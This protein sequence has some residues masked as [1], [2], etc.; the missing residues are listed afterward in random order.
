MAFGVFLLVVPLALAVMLWPMI[1]ALRRERAIRRAHSLHEASI[2]REANALRVAEAHAALCAAASDLRMADYLAS[3]EIPGW[4]AEHRMAIA[5]TSLSYLAPLLPPGQQDEFRRWC[6]SFSDLS[7]TIA[8]HN[9]RVVSRQVEEEAHFF[10][11]IVGNPL[12]QRQREAIVTNEDT[13]LVVAGAGTGK[14]RV[15]AAKVAWLLH[16][17]LAR[18]EEILVLAYNRKA[19]EEIKGRL[20]SIP[21]ASEVM[22]ST[23]H[24]FGLSILANAS[25]EKPSVSALADDRLAKRRLIHDRLKIMLADPDGRNLLVNHF[26]RELDPGP[27]VDARVWTEA[28]RRDMSSVMVGL[29]NEHNVQIAVDERTAAEWVWLLKQERYGTRDLTGV[30]MRSRQEV[31]IANWLTLNGIRWE[32]ERTYNFRTAT[33]ERRQYQP[34]FYLPDHDL[35]I[36]HYG[37]GRHGETA[38]GVDRREYRKSMEWKRTTHLIH[39][40]VCIETFGYQDADRTLFPILEQQLRN[41]GVVPRDLTSQEIVGIVDGSHDGFSSLSQLLG[42]ALS[43][44]RGSGKSRES[45]LS[46]A[47]S[48][49]DHQFLTIL[50]AVLSDY[51]AELKRSGTIDFDDMILQARA[52]L[53]SGEVMSP[54][55]YILVDEFQDMTENRLA[56][57]QDVRNH[58]SHARLFVVGDD[59]QSIYR[60][61]GSDVSLMTD[62]SRHV[63]ATARVDLDVNFRYGQELLDVSATFIQRNPGQLRK[64]LHAQAGSGESLPICLLVAPWD[65]Q[66][67]MPS[68]ELLREAVD[69][70]LCRREMAQVEGATSVLVL[71][72]YHSTRPMMFERLAKEMESQGID[73]TFS[74]VHSA[75]GMEADY[76]VL[77]DAVEGVQGFPSEIQDDPVLRMFLAADDVFPD[78]EERR[79]FYVALTRARKRVYITTQTG[80]LS[81][82]IDDDLL[83]DY[84]LPFVERRG[85]LAGRYR[86]PVCNELSITR[87]ENDYGPWWPCSR[88]PL[89]SGKLQMC[90]TCQEG[91]LER[92]PSDNGEGCAYLCTVCRTTHP[93]GATPV[94]PGDRMRSQRAPVL[95]PVPG[96]RPQM[97]GR[98]DLDTVPF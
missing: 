55:R 97:P 95:A 58:V 3:S 17:G 22:A 49:R 82:F 15:I 74:T 51:E 87:R 30:K 83:A 27:D 71:G 72:R 54:Y 73:L 86:C 76:V 89:C 50:F 91:G 23:M 8:L 40:T 56:L 28:D 2:E 43:L 61:S 37:V 9:A 67:R 7:G 26:S 69:D 24:A 12:T 13:T 19:A 66:R 21:G 88:Y 31:K 33:M 77:L 92:V 48:E 1:G 42:T 65:G 46:K 79:L 32:Y 98:D 45:L 20:G 10:D 14:T 36:E 16:R 59:W 38:K 90:P 80:R 25:G 4:A 35:W 93:A 63:G 39:G 70:I 5:A 75:K 62:L 94:R 44:L 47:R 68:F 64:R 81:R 41:H 60:F 18:Q 11:H 53:R 57:L 84:A 52:A 29:R 78:G 85:D 34:D 6:G 96:L